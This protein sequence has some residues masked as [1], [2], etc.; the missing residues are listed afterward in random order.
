MNDRGKMLGLAFS[1]IFLALGASIVLPE[2]FGNLVQNQT[3][4]NEAMYS[5]M[6]ILLVIFVFFII[7]AASSK[8]VG[9]MDG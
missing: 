3:A 6:R 2:L 9:G 4:D 1:M 7:A 8:I 5:S